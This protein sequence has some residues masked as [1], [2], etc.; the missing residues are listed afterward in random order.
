MVAQLML[1]L[2]LLILLMLDGHIDLLRHYGKLKSQL[3]KV[4]HLQINL[5][6]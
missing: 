6:L 1:L 4:A 5:K 2:L 3:V